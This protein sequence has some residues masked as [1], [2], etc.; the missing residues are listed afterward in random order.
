M[1]VVVEDADTS[2]TDVQAKIKASEEIETRLN[3][4]SF[5]LDH[6]YFGMDLTAGSDEEWAM[7]SM[8]EYEAPMDGNM[9]G[10]AAF[11]NPYLSDGINTIT[12][13]YT[14]NGKEYNSRISRRMRYE[15]CRSG[16]S[17]TSRTP[18]W[19]TTRTTTG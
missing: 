7:K 10:T 2:D 9:S 5:M 8:G 14:M 16:T 4:G 19:A 12:E 17:R 11:Y 1:K 18:S 15:E 3:E 13:W 6:G